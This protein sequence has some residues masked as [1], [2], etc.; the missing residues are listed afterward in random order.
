MIS[1]TEALGFV[2]ALAMVACS[3]RELHWSWPLAIASS[4]LYFFVFKD[5]LLYAE[6]GLQ[7]G[8]AALAVW[9]WCQ[10]LRKN[11]E[12]EPIWV[13]QRL[14]ARGWWLAGA[15]LTLLWSTLTWLLTHYTDSDVAAWDAL[16]TSLSLIGQVMLGRKYLENWLIWAAVNAMSV[17]LFAYKG[18]WLTSLL[19]GL[20]IGLCVLGW[21]AWQKRLPTT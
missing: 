21:R 2:L 6:A 9:G 1:W 5:S 8:F 17:G 20:F 12:Q 13:I 19:Y 10:W 16:L 7:L 15:A 4:L 18:L 3:I 14:P 11:G